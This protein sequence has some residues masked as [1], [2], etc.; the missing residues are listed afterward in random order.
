M[1]RVDEFTNPLH[2]EKYQNKDIR[3][4]KEIYVSQKS[5]LIY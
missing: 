5:E 4:R 1:D 3:R 2:H